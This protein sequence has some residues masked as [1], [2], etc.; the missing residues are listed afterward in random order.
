MA[1]GAALFGNKI[2]RF[3]IDTP[4]SLSELVMLLFESY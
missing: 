1:L 4:D 2:R 3:F